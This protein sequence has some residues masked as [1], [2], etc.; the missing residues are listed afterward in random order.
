VSTAVGPALHHAAGTNGPPILLIHGFGA[1]RMSWLV[2]LQKL[3]AA[4]KIYTLDLPGHGETPLAGAGRLDDLACAVTETIDTSG[5]GPTD[6][7]AHSLGGSVA[8]AVAA[9]RPDLVRSLALIAAAGLGGEVS[10]GFL[11]EYPRCESPEVTE[12]LLR[13]LVSR[14]RL[15]SRYMVDRVLERL[16]SSGTREALIAIA[17]ELRRIG[18]VIEPSL[19]TVTASTLPRLVIWGQADEIIPLD[20]ERLSSFR[21]ERLILPDVAHMPHIEA[22]S[23]VNEH[24]LDWLTAQ[25]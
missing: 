12:A 11:S 5:I 13:R 4:G 7:V 22:P 8:I 18:T 24:L 23:K 16:N 19:Q 10:E 9:A 20:T 17:N 1:D 2:N 15:I 21:G 3:S 14:P 25:S 6:I